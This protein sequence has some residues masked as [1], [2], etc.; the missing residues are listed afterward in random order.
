MTALFALLLLPG[1]LSICPMLLVRCSKGLLLW[2]FGGAQGK[3]QASDSE[4]PSW[5]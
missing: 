3:E 4:T 1:V 2:L 5:M